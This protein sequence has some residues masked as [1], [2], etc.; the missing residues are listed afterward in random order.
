M[1]NQYDNLLKQ[2][3]NEEDIDLFKRIKRLIGLLMREKK[4]N[5]SRVLSSGDYFIDRWERS[6]FNGF[7]DGSSVYDSCLVLGEVRVGKNTWVGPYTVLDGSGGG[8][9]IGDDC[10]I[11]AGVHLYTHDT[12]NR[13]ISGGP[14]ETAPVKIGNH[15][16]IGPHTVIA[17][18]VTIG[19]YVVIGANSLVNC[20]LPDGVKAY[21]TPAV[22]T[23][24][25]GRKMNEES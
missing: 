15:V 18:G 8:L 7:G 25:S 19:N 24:S 5:H 17:K 23:G 1:K 21:G 14:I 4:N 11:S 13:V 12:V 16:Y 3:G 10:N 9:E 2:G 22:A 6:K 20:N